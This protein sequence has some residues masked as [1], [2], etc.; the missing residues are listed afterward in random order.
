MYA[1]PLCNGLKSINLNCP[2]CQ[3]VMDNQGRTVDFMGDYIPYLEYEGT[4]LIDG[5]LNSTQDHTCLHLFYC[6]SCN[7]QLNVPIQEIR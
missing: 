4:K 2:N 5:E 6:T 1:C 7:Q 3:Q